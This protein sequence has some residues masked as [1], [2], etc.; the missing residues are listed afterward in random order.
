MAFLTGLREADPDMYERLETHQLGGFTAASQTDYAAAL[1]MV[2][3]WRRRGR[4]PNRRFGDL[5]Q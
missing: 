5:V 1:D 4:K 2:G 3:C